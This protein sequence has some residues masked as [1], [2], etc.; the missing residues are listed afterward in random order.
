MGFW[1]AHLTNLEALGIAFSPLFEKVLN[2]GGEV[3]R[4]RHLLAPD[5][6][7]EYQEFC[8]DQFDEPVYVIERVKTYPV[9]GIVD[10]GYHGLHLASKLLEEEY[11]DDWKD[12]P[13]FI[14]Y[15]EDEDRYCMGGPLDECYRAETLQYYRFWDCYPLVDEQLYLDLAAAGVK[16]L[17]DSRFGEVALV[18][19]FE[20]DDGEQA[21][22]IEDLWYL[23][24]DPSKLDRATVEHYE[25]WAVMRGH[26][27]DYVRGVLEAYE[28]LVEDEYLPP[29]WYSREDGPWEGKHLQLPPM[30]AYLQGKPLALDVWKTMRA[31]HD[32]SIMHLQAIMTPRE[33][34]SFNHH[35]GDFF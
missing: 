28:G 33:R 4:L 14:G 16:R 32:L 12:Y 29:P 21:T 23:K 35:E 10:D 8:Y 30:E 17:N 25:E 15:L 26:T 1:D 20:F 31:A 27:D 13:S 9:D 7:P 5:S 34:D 3:L 22:S 6:T 2:E 19:A 24:N 18:A 11:G